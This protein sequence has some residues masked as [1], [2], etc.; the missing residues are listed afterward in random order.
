MV[1]VTGT[2]PETEE[3]LVSVEEYIDRF[4]DGGEKP[5]CEYVDGE[6]FPKSM[7]TKKHS[8]TQQNIQYSIRQKYGEA[9]DPLPELTT[10]LRKKKFYVP[11][12][13]IEDRAHPIQGRYPG[14]EDHREPIPGGI[15]S[16]RCKYWRIPQSALRLRFQ[17]DHII[18]EQ[19]GGETVLGN[20][21]FACP[22]CNRYKNPNIAGLD[23]QSGQLVRL[24]HPRT[25]DWIH[26]DS[27]CASSS[28]GSPFLEERDT[29]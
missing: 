16:Q 15:Q 22:H 10:R 8:K 19:H 23:S 21:A 13:A 28:R 6:L 14:P 1:A 5:T 18:A 3:A 27:G 11:D 25:D 20:L 26:C 29:G 7:G 24:F 12:I 9:F 4:V 2:M 17:I